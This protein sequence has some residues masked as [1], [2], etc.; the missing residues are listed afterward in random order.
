MAPT[1]TSCDLTELGDLLAE[2]V[3]A[4][5]ALLAAALLDVAEWLQ[6]GLDLMDAPVSPQAALFV[7]LSYLQRQVDV[8][9]LK[10]V[11][12]AKYAGHIARFCRHLEHVEGV[13]DVRVVGRSEALNF[14]HSP[15]ARKDGALVASKP[16]GATKRN[17]R[18]ALD[19]FFEALIPLGVTERHPLTGATFPR[20][21]GVS[22]LPLADAQVRKG[23]LHSEA[24]FGDL[25]G[26][27]AWAFAEGSATTSEL[28]LI[29]RADVDLERGRFWCPGGP[30]ASA[31]WCLLTDWGV[32]KVDALLGSLPAGFD[33]PL[34]YS[35][36]AGSVS[37]QAVACDLIH[38]T[39]KR[40]GLGGDPRI[41]PSSLRGWCGAGIYAVTGDLTVVA[42]RLGLADLD[43][44]ATLIGLIRPPVDVPPAHR[45]EASP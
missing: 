13:V 22:P 40:A 31:R 35:G 24:F 34:L 8:D 44:C 6:A 43:A 37:A 30:R 9:V 14:V 42:H 1:L 36:S 2:H 10:A 33:G 11:S 19:H 32:E 41:R 25:R 18:A 39:L 29:V 20:E 28:P 27:A 3:L 38:E 23:R 4:R 26:P 7:A 12:A 45:A 21:P 5:R 16:S 15:A 17:R